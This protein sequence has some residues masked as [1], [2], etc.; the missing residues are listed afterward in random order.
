V[1]ST[2]LCAIQLEKYYA[3]TAASASKVRV[4]H[5]RVTARQVCLIDDDKLTVILN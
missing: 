3:K 4:C 2:W 5:F 1:K